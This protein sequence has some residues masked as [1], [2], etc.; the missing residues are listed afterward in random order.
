MQPGTLAS[1]RQAARRNSIFQL[2][3]IARGSNRHFLRRLETFATSTKQTAEHDSNRHNRATFASPS[4][5]FAP[6]FSLNAPRQFATQIAYECSCNQLKTQHIAC[7]RRNNNP[8]VAIRVFE[9]QITSTFEWILRRRRSIL[10]GRRRKSFNAATTLPSL[11][12]KASAVT[13]P[14]LREAPTFR[15]EVSPSL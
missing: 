8:P 5:I 11:R 9:R 15:G 13:L 1:G 3:P 4:P 7:S 10:A 14:G 6:R 12:V 2:N